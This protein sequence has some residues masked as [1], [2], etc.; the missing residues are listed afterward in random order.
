MK[1]V[2]LGGMSRNK[3][4]K[5]QRAFGSVSTAGFMSALRLRTIGNVSHALASGRRSRSTTDT[6]RE[7]RGCCCSKRTA[8]KELLTRQTSNNW[9]IEAQ[10]DHIKSRTV[11]SL[12]DVTPDAH[13][14]S[15]QALRDVLVR[16]WTMTA[17]PPSQMLS[18]NT[19]VKF[20]S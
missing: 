18:L 20:P 14:V 3:R 9:Y 4:T 10:D 19:L 6:G 12:A 1:R 13:A 17:K 8:S 15:R 2:W 7:A 5:A 16:H 11:R